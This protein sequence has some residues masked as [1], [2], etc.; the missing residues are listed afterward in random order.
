MTFIRKLGVGFSSWIVSVLSLMIMLTDS[1]G[2]V[3]MLL[4]YDEKYAYIILLLISYD[5]NCLL[6]VRV[7]HGRLVHY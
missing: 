5:E 7:S 6:F 1:V 2:C 4:K 3:C